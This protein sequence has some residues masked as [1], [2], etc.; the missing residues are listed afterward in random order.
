M[1]GIENGPYERMLHGSCA[2]VC[3][4]RV[5][6]LVSICQLF[7]LCDVYVRC[8]VSVSRQIGS[9]QQANQAVSLCTIIFVCPEGPMHFCSKHIPG[10]PRSPST[11][12]L[13]L[14]LESN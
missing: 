14:S 4:V 1:N 5:K 7:R 9:D 12:E 13:L 3:A 8:M 6:V 11:V 2:C 10:T